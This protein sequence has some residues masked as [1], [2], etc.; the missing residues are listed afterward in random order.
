MRKLIKYI[1]VL[2][3]VPMVNVTI[4]QQ[5]YLFTHYMNNRM[6]LNPGY[7]GSFDAISLTATHRSQ[8]IAFDG[9]PNT[10]NVSFQMPI[11]SQNLG[12]GAAI[13]HDQIGPTRNI[14]VDANVA[15]H[16]KL[17]QKSKL[18]LGLRA[19][20]YFFSNKLS[21]LKTVEENDVSFSEDIRNKFS[22][23]VGFGAYY[24]DDV[25]FGGISI[26]RIL[27]NSFKS[28][29]IGGAVYSSAYEKRHFYLLGGALF[30]VSKGGEVKLRPSMLVKVTGGAPIQMDLSTA[31]IYKDFFE[32]GLSWRSGDAISVLLGFTIAEVFTIGYSYDYSYGNTTF[33]YNG[34]SHEVALKYNI[35]KKQK[36]NATSF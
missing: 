10:Q 16:L 17:G 33:R 1:L 32:V 13:V 12:V 29:D 36:E 18:G 21:S 24:Y 30:N 20:A 2:F 25:F 4:A 35:F 34:G 9:A 26:P 8:W 27:Q 31:M 15:Y 5:E 11:S 14:G 6:S 19:G 3:A 23:N 28:K 22:P 7:T